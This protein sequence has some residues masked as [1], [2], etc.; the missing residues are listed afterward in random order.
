MTVDTSPDG[1]NLR[2]C[3]WAGSLIEHARIKTHRADAHASTASRF[4]HLH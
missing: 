2:E 1:P 4:D 3:S